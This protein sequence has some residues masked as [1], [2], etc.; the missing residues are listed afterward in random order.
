MHRPPALPGLVVY[1]VPVPGRR[2]VLGADPAEGN[3][4][5]DESALTVLD[6][7]TGEEVASLA[8]RFEPATFAAHIDQV[9]RYYH[10]AGVLVERNNHGHAVLAWLGDNR[11]ST[12][13]RLCGDDGRPGWNTTTKS[14]AMLYAEAGEALRDGEAV[15]HGLDVFHQLTSVEGSTLRA[16]EGQPDDR[17]V[18]FALALAGRAKLLR[19]STAALQ[20]GPVVLIPGHQGSGGPTTWGCSTCTATPGNGAKIDMMKTLR[21]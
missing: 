20:Q 6:V 16:P 4:I 17:A 18:A 11:N 7:L 2:Y 14:K 12:L 21:I 10:A 15:L 8:G 5:S 13:P 19:R 1:A 3:P 9:G